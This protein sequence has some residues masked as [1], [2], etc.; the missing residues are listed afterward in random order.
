MIIALNSAKPHQTAQHQ[1]YSK[2]NG[3]I[4]VP[5]TDSKKERKKSCKYK[6]EIKLISNPGIMV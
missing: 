5:I 6:K 3:L 2:I 1:P 4:I